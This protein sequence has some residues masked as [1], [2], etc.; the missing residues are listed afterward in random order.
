MQRPRGECRQLCWRQ[1]VSVS[2][3]QCVRR[4]GLKGQWRLI[5]EQEVGC[6]IDSEGLGKPLRVPGTSMTSSDL[7][8]ENPLAVG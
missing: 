2:G 1:E 8:S 4:N 6:G 3:S 7:W 5:Q